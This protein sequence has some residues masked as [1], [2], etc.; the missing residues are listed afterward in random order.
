MSDRTN[1]V[2]KDLHLKDHPGALKSYL[3]EIE[4]FIKF[5]YFNILFPLLK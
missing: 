2:N 5:N 4:E 1:A 3:P